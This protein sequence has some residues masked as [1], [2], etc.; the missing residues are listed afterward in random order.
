M[1]HGGNMDTVLTP[2]KGKRFT[3]DD[4]VKG[5]GQLRVMTKEGDFKFI[6]DHTNKK[7]AKVAKET[8]DKYVKDGFIAFHVKKDGEKGV[9]MRKFDPEAEKIIMVPQMSGG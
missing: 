3:S 2:A 4:I 5:Q 8:Y 7:E 1:T 6:W 9:K